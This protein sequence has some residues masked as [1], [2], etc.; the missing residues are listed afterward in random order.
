MDYL[1]RE[2]QRRNNIHY[3]IGSCYWLAAVIF[4]L[5][6]PGPSPFYTLTSLCLSSSNA[7]QKGSHSSAVYLLTYSL[8]KN[9][10]CLL[11]GK[12]SGSCKGETA[13]ASVKRHL[14]RS[15]MARRRVA[16]LAG[17]VS[18]NTTSKFN[19]ESETWGRKNESM[20]RYPERR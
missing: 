12:S 5:L 9:K 2:L 15:R 6:N 17:C 16:I 11:F 1:L 3:L 13:M 10:S 4:C 18:V 20:V 7:S 14:Q 19:T 8:S